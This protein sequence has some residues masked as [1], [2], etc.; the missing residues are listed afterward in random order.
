MK[1][2]ILFDLD[3]TLTDSAE[4]ILNS[5]TLALTH[6]NIPV[7]GRE[8]LREFIGPPLIPMFI[9]YGIPEENAKE[10]LQIFRGR[11]TTVGKFENAPYPGIPALLQA[12]KAEGH[13]LL[14][15]TSKPETQATEILDHFQLSSYFDCIC[16]ASQDETRATKE[17]VIAYLL[18]QNGTADHMVMVG[19]T[20]YDI[21]G[22][23]AHGIPAIGV[24]WGYGNTEDMKKAGAIAI[25]DTVQELQKILEAPV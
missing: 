3:G 14:V 22:A 12:L 10:A 16:G 9:K 21:I 8:A 24:S 6:F 5:V 11:Y 2:T 1:K 19:D 7:P 13:R 23:K 25:A 4:G 18:L 15:A 17:D 20:H